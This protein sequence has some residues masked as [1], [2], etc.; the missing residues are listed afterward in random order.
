MLCVSFSMCTFIINHHFSQF[1]HLSYNMTS[2]YDCFVTWNR[3]TSTLDICARHPKTDVELFMRWSKVVK[4]WYFIHDSWYFSLV[5]Y[6]NRMFSHFIIIISLTWR[7]LPLRRILQKQVNSEFSKISSFFFKT[8]YF[9]I[10][11]HCH[12]KFREFHD[13]CKSAPVFCLRLI[14]WLIDV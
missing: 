12:A 1:K 14:A 11:H 7:N 9:F 3:K 4:I 13:F 8:A 5:K 2:Y 10:W 6:Q